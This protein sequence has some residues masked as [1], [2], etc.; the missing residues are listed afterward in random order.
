MNLFQ[1]SSPLSRCL[2]VDD[3]WLL[4][5]Q[6]GH[7]AMLDEWQENLAIMAANRTQG[8]ERVMLYLGDRLW[9]ARG[10]V[11]VFSCSCIP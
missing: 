9:S 11:S 8:D 5:L 4:A 2:D 10:E 6:D 7:E 3:Q 1:Y